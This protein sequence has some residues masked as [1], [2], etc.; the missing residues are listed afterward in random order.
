MAGEKTEQATPK[1]RR[2]ARKEGD[3]ATSKDVIMVVSLLGSFLILKLFFP[4]I[5]ETLREEMIKI[6]HDVAQISDLPMGT[7]REIG[8]E[9]VLLIVKCAFPLGI[10]GIAIAV[11]ATGVQTRFLFTTKP[12]SFKLSK[13]SIL[14]GIKN[15]FSPK[16]LIEML[17][18]V[19]KIIVLSVVLYQVLKDEIVN[20]ARMLD[21]A[22]IS[23]AAFTLNEVMS[24]VF[25]IVLVF[26]AIAGFD[27]FYQR[28]SYEKKLKMS[29]EEVKEENKQTEGNPE[30][31]GRIRSLQ[32][33]MAR[34]RMMQAVP[35]AD[36][37]IRNPTHFA[38]ALKYDI[39]HD[40]APVLIAKG[41]DQIAFK[42]IEIGQKSGVAIVENRPLARGIYA[43]T[44]LDSEIPPEYYGVVAEIL[45]QVFRMNKKME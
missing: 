12:L 11:I 41:Q 6:L 8:M 34:N 16:N 39:D 35:D 10:I 33:N 40:N 21:M 17:K 44:P 9:A 36:V 7:L 32:R 14:K 25:K 2:D 31:K 4:F 42:I 30:I 22:P 45:V 27:F 3:V 28:W 29:K 26:G 20:V 18:A 13:L 37:I 43:S 23:A 15:L 38:V 19:L 5:Y 24:I 1:K